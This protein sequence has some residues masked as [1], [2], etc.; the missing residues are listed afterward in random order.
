MAVS[1]FFARSVVAGVVSLALVV[2]VITPVQAAEVEEVF[3]P[4]VVPPIVSPVVEVPESVVPEGDFSSLTGETGM[5]AG[6]AVEVFT[7]ESILP[8]RRRAE[9]SE[10]AAVDALNLATAE[11]LERSEFETVYENPVGGGTLVSSMVPLNAEASDG[12]WVPIDT[13]LSREA[14]GSYS[15]DEHPLDPSF[16]P[17]AGD[18]GV[19]E[20][21][22][23][24]YRV[25]FTLEG[26]ADSAISRGYRQPRTVSGGDD[27]SYDEVFEGVDLEFGVERGWVKEELVLNEL[28]DR[29]EASYTWLVEADALD[30]RFDEF[31]N[32]EF[33]N[34]YGQV[35]F[36][37][38]V[39]V[40]W[41]SSGVEGVSEDALE[42]VDAE[43]TETADG[44]ELTLTP[45]YGWLSDPARVFPVSIDPTMISGEANRV[46]YKQDGARR[47]DATF[48]GNAQSG[49]WK[50]WRTVI[51]YP[52]SSLSGYQVT[53]AYLRITHAYQGYVGTASGG[54]TRR[55]GIASGVWASTWRAP[56]SG[57]APITT[58]AGR[59][60]CGMRRWCGMATS[61]PG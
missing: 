38:P 27:F 22:R 56:R 12:E 2:S 5:T 4:G 32:I 36:Y 51:V 10:P 19:F 24:G 49:A 52:Y 59:W 13:S 53:N 46:A 61:A 33:V 3:D 21:A 48:V 17:S 41:D 31:G 34:R 7:E 1:G 20:V 28:P 55:P 40:M 47:T 43:L 15:T 8:T 14:D 58:V 11:V 6:G 39:P 60:R 35:Q 29:A 45:D 54:I 44:W 42:N 25:S 50:N 57:S 26:A 16:A 9:P 18:E 30:L 37:I 23:D